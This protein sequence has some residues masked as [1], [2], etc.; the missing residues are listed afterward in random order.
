MITIRLQE[1]KIVLILD[2]KRLTETELKALATQ[3]KGIGETKLLIAWNQAQQS[4]PGP[5][6]A[7]TDYRKAEN[8]YGAKYGNLEWERMLGSSRLM[9]L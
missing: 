1:K 4:L 2:R 7:K 5:R 8:M 9:P 3:V 6:P